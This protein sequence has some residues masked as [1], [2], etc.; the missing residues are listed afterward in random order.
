MKRIFRAAIAAFF[1]KICAACKEL[2]P[3]EEWLCENCRKAIRRCDPAVRCLSCGLPKK[4]CVCKSRIFR[5]EGCVAPFVHSGVAREAMNR[6]KFR[7]RMASARFFAEQMAVCVEKEYADIHFDSICYV[8]MH[9]RKQFARGFQPALG[10]A[11]SLSRILKIPVEYGLLACTRYTKTPQHKLKFK[12]RQENVRNLYRATRQ[13]EGK[14]LLL[15]DDIKTSGSTLDECAKQLIN[16]GAT[17]VWCVT[18][19]ISYPQEKKKKV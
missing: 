7:D 14:T 1:P 19:L 15:V 8:P 9:T 13:A 12:E 10:L 17:A 2:I 16:A 11:K 4:Q 18:A 6:Y 3:E 5:F